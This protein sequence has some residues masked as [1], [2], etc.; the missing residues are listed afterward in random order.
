MKKTNILIT[1][2]DPALLCAYGRIVAAAG[3]EVL[4]AA[5]GEECLRCAGEAQPDLILLDSVLPDMDGVEV[6]RRLK[7]GA[8]TGRAFIILISGHHVSPEEQAKALESGADGYLTKPVAERALVAHIRALLRIKQA[9]HELRESE[10]RHRLMAE[11]LQEANRRLEEY[12][13]LKTEFVANMSHELR[14]PLNAIIG[15]AQLAGLAA[16][17]QSVPPPYAEAMQR[18]LRNSRHLLSLIDDVLDIA[19]LEAGRIRIHREHFDVADLVQSAFA[20]LQS[21]AAQKGIGYTL[22][23]KDEIPL[24]F[25][26][27]LRVRQ[28]VI[29]LL[30]NAIKF[31]ERGAVGVEVRRAGEAEFEIVVRDTGVGIDARSLDIIFERFRQVDGSM[32]RRAGGTGLGLAI[33]Q[34]VAGLLGGRVAVTSEVGAGSVFT[35]TLPLAAPAGVEVQPATTEATGAAEEA[36][37]QA[38]E[39]LR[40]RVEA[41]AAEQQMDRPLVLVVEDNPEMNR[42]VA[43]TLAAEYRVATAFDGEQGFERALALRPDLILSDVMMPRLSGDQ[44]VRRLRERE[45][46]DAVPVVLL[47]AKADDEL[48]V[49]LLREGAQDYVMKPFSAEELRARVSNLVTMKRAREVLQ[50]EL[51]TQLRDLE[52]LAKEVTFRKRELQTSYEAMRLA[53]EQAERASQVKSDFLRLV[54]HELRTPLTAI[55]GYLEILRRAKSEALSE[56]QQQLVGKIGRSANRLRDLVESLLE[57]TRIQSGR[58][59]VRAE[60]LDLAALAADVADELR[61]QAEQKGLT[62]AVE[63]AAPLPTLSSDARLVR[64]VLV[65]L[66]GNAVK[67]TV[68]GGV[69]VSLAERDGQH[70]V[71][72]ADTG[73]GIRPEHQALVFEPFGQLGEVDK[74]HQP[75]FGLGL[76]LVRQIVDALGGKVELHS[77]EGRG[78]TF[79]VSLPPAAAGEE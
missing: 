21:L 48:R 38:M 61:P 78:A 49:R 12:N 2:D 60:P 34:Q 53:R 50:R 26:D 56:P 66:I 4:K 25:S 65:N 14:T 69:T 76:A 41:A 47:T 29:N 55:S 46:L 72:V 6:C 77:A 42:F 28:I 54:S 10:E 8:Q 63:P 30:S 40:T 39:E 52:S 20:E 71:S 35:V 11:D 16:G 67:F 75:G 31:T 70:L 57:Y 45:E 3:Y 59:V 73:P 51:D 33:V 1:E 36:A 32:T 64:L 5:T 7:S 68:R 19:K 79:T 15:F 43:E 18:I 22:A 37:R 24:A 13:R 74:K 9:E 44:L 23:V 62:L 27:P 17:G 58:I